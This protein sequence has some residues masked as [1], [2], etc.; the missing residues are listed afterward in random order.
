VAFARKG[1]WALGVDIRWLVGYHLVRFVGFYFLYLYARNE[2][3]FRFAVWGG[4]G[5]I[6][7]AT[8]AILVILFSHKSP[9][10]L[11]LWNLFGRADILGVAATAA[12]SELAGPGSNSSSIIFH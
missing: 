12:R 10:A 3:P 4:Q 1:Q 2:L 9:A 8:L 6:A 11:I 5:D 7:V